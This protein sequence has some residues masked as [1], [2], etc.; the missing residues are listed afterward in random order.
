LNAGSSKVPQVL[1]GMLD[2]ALDGGA[3]PHV[4]VILRSEEEFAP[5]V[6]S[7]YT[8]GAKRGGW[9]VH[10]SVEPQRDRE[11]LTGAGLDVP[12]LEAERRLALE[13]IRRSEPPEQLPRRLDAAF[14]EALTRGLSAL[15]SS[16]TPVSADSDSFDHAMEVE[17]AWEE[18]FRDRPVITLCPY[19]VG[20][21]DA[22]AALGRLTGLGAGHHD[23]VLL[24]SGDG[25]ELFR[26]ARAAGDP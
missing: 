23:G 26:P 25:L 7:F 22:P 18:H 4:A 6:A 2:P 19:I 10:R 24:P 8:L 14:D 12:A 16:H 13:Q 5:V 17:R 21:L 9:L 3:C 1:S 11:A 15:W 20:G